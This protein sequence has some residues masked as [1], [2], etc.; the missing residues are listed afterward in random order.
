MSASTILGWAA[1]PQVGLYLAAMGAG[2]ALGLA[3]PGAGSLDVA[4]N[5]VIRASTT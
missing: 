1:R 4:I 5:P 2:L 3:V